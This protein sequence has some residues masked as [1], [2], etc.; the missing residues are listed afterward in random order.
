MVPGPL[1]ALA[2]IG[3]SALSRASMVVLMRTLPPARGGGLGRSVGTPPARSM[4]GAIV[5]ACG[6]TLLLGLVVGHIWAAVLM[7]VVTGAATCGCARIARAKIGGFTG[8]ILGGTQQACDVAM[9]I[10]LSAVAY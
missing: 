1:F 2:L 3:G 9:L 5:I 7:I 6:G 8:D 10:A 4:W